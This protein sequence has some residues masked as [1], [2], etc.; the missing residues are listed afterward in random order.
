[1]VLLRS[2][3][4]A[5]M[6]HVW[7]VPDCCAA[8]VLY[9]HFDMM[10]GRFEN[11]SYTGMFIDMGASHTSAF[12]SEYA[13]VLDCSAFL[14]VAKHHGEIVRLHDERERTGR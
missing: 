3:E 8:S 4:M 12:I 14:R 11:Q 13:G 5:G 6:K 9:G 2:A 7:L 1:M 10:G